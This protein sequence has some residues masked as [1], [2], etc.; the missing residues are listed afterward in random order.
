LS[1]E[2]KAMQQPETNLNNA[3]KLPFAIML[4]ILLFAAF[5]AYTIWIE[6]A[7]FEYN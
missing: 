6:K 2:S 7:D 1:R 3:L 4:L 5:W